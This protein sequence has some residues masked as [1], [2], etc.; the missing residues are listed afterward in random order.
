MPTGFESADCVVTWSDYLLT[1]DALG[2][3]LLVEF[4]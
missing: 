3:R 1:I 2:C 4:V